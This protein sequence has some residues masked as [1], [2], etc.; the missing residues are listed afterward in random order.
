MCSSEIYS[1]FINKT[2][3]DS[4]KTAIPKEAVLPRQ[5]NDSPSPESVRQQDGCYPN[6][7]P[8]CLPQHPLRHQR[9][10]PTASAASKVEYSSLSAPLSKVQIILTYINIYVNTF[11]EKVFSHRFIICFSDFKTL[12]EGR[13][14]SVLFALDKTF[15]YCYDI[16]RNQP[17]L[18]THTM[19]LEPARSFTDYPTTLPEEIPSATAVTILHH[20]LK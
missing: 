20:I 13:R 11:Y 8:R 2:K 12:K 18:S 6:C 14:K 7:Q 17:R 10:S 15:I 19:P 5:V 16:I 3:K 9:L 4:R 1:K